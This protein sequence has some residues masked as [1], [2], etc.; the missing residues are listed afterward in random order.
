MLCQFCRKEYITITSP[1]TGCCEEARRKHALDQFDKDVAAGRKQESVEIVAYEHDLTAI[2][3]ALD[4]VRAPHDPVDGIS[5]EEKR[6]RLLAE[7]RD[8]L[9]QQLEDASNAIDFAGTGND[10][11]EIRVADLCT[12]VRS[13]I[14]QRDN[15]RQQ[16]QAESGKDVIA[17]DLLKVIAAS[18]Q[19]WEMIDLAYRGFYANHPEITNILANSRHC[20]E[21]WKR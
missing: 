8:H 3:R 19:G 16:L 20:P 12:T 10:P 17:R 4:E 14:V 2:R 1:W 5:I 9:Q 21:G 13:L 11:L 15:F 7:E 6:I 18:A